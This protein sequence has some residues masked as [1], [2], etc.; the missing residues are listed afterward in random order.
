MDAIDAI[1]VR[2][3]SAPETSPLNAT[4]K[5]MAISLK[6]ALLANATRAL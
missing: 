4:R 3:Q 1:I 6:V 2:R 5:A